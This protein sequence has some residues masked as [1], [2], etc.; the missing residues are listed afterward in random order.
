MELTLLE[1]NLEEPSFRANAPFSSPGRD[2]DDESATDVDV[3]YGEASEESSRR[4]PSAKA[5]VAGLLFLVA[6]GLAARRF[7]G[8]DSESVETE[9]DAERITA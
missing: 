4:G 5:F 7:M 6:V 8:G 9:S 1:V 3:E 2:V